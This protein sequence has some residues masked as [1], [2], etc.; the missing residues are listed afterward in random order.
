MKVLDTYPKAT[1]TDI[2]A[3]V[4]FNMEHC[5]YVHLCIVVKSQCQQWF[6]RFQGIAASFKLLNKILHILNVVNL[7]FPDAIP[8]K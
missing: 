7:Y 8:I 2:T 4:A 5:L 1:N 3:F 6:E